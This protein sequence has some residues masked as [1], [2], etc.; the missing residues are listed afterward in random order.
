MI[1]NYEDTDLF[2]N[3]SENGY[4]FYKQNVKM[5]EEFSDYRWNEFIVIVVLCILLVSLLKLD[6][7]IA[8]KDRWNT[9][10]IWMISE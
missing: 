4:N 5:I 3:V 7:D 10:D 2:P 1:Q 8:R 9:S 6:L